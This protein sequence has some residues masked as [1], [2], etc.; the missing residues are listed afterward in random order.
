MTHA[1]APP[2]LGPV[3]L[4]ETLGRAVNALR[5]HL[6]DRL[7]AAAHFG[8]TARGDARPDSD[9]DVLVVVRDLPR[10][11][12]A[13]S[14]CLGPVRDP[15]FDTPVSFVPRSAEEFERDITPLHLDL[16]LDARVLFE[17]DG[18]LSNRLSLVRR[19]LDEAGLYRGTD[20]FWHWRRVPTRAEWGI[21]WDRV[22][23]E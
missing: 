20:R 11:A 17:R 10:E 13:I 7:L 15:L 23:V 16:A 5:Q 4:Q 22:E 6:G 2:Y 8:S 21:Y 3:T 9:I 14:E 12:R 1:M 19:R 18:Y